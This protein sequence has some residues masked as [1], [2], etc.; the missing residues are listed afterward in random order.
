[1]EQEVEQEDPPFLHDFTARLLLDE[2]SEITD[3]DCSIGSDSDGALT[4]AIW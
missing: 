1:M 4:P 3:E 2:D